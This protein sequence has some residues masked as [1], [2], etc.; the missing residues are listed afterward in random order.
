M[1]STITHAD[2]TPTI[3][4]I[5]HGTGTSSSVPNIACITA[6]PVTCETCGST[7]TPKGWKNKRRNTGGILRILGEN[8]T[9]KVIVIDV[10]K[11]FL[12]AAYDLFPRYGL[13]QIDAV[14]LTHPH[15]DA[16]NGLDDLRGW[17]LNKSIQ[18][19]I[20]VYVSAFTFKEV[21]K[22]FPYLVAKEFATGGGD[23][24]EFRWHIIKENEP[25]RVDGVDFDITPIVVH[26][27]RL[28]TTGTE[29]PG[30]VSTPNDTPIPSGTATP[31]RAVPNSTA[32]DSSRPVSRGS[33]V[34]II[35][36]RAT[37]AVDALNTNAVNSSIKQKPTIIEKLPPSNHAPVTK[38]KPY[39][40]FGFIFGDFMVYMSDVSH[41]P[42]DAWKTI[43]SR[44]PASLSLNGSGSGH[45][46]STQARYK[47][48]VVDCLKLE[49]HTSHFG[50]QG[51]LDAAKQ[52]NA[53]RT[54]MVGF[55]HRITHD[56]W[57]TIGEY[58]E[59]KNL[60]DVQLKRPN[61]AQALRILPPP[62]EETVW[63]RPAFDGLRLFGNKGAVWEDVL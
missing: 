33:S 35:E 27:G 18:S 37:T 54:Y 41:I 19:H 32:H 46:I 59:G 58:I 56:D 39:L 12:S 26:H 22:S 14:I 16:V 47:V 62:G 60:D 3:E 61:V 25:F 11:T 6:E 8:Q 48:L 49:P 63:I 31:A 10:G 44:S 53:H 52:I 13:R 1:T 43:Q 4:F 20:D 30:N 51:A 38:P 9:S 28:F 24:P 5:F 29:G 55:S 7:L 42:E 17:T 23:I 50:L 45:E 57:D 2:G 21:Q 40:C 15:A 34:E 36:Q